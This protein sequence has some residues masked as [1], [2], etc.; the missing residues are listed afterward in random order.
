MAS[1]DGKRLA[2]PIDVANN[3][4]PYNYELL[5]RSSSFKRKQIEKE[6]VRLHKISRHR[7]FLWRRTLSIRISTGTQGYYLMLIPIDGGDFYHQVT[8]L[9]ASL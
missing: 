6:S 8:R 7:G 3:M 2:Q 4:D 9:F 5:A 1:R